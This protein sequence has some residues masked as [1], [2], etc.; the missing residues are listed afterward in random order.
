MIDHVSVPVRNLA[1]ATAFYDAVLI[2]L[3]MSRLVTRERTAGYGKR[4]PEFWVNVREDF[5][6]TSDPGAHVALRA[7]TENAVR[8]FYE[9]ALSNGGRDDGPPGPRQGEMTAYIG[10]FI[11]DPDGN[12]IEVVTFPATGD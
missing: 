10:V 7:K 9:A 12:R 2:P 6:L 5:P 4:Y 11:L 8:D 3:G 1:R